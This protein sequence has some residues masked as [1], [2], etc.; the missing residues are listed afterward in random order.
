MESILTP[1]IPSSSHTDTTANS[2]KMK[3][4]LLAPGT[5][6]SVAKIVCDN[7]VLSSD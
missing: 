4:N 1:S 6:L 7:E 5:F 2:G 3:T